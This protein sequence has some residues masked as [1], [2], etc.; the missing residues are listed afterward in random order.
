M[1]FLLGMLAS[2][3][4]AI[5]TALGAVPVVVWLCLACVV[6]GMILVS[7][8]CSCR[9]DRSQERTVGPYTVVSVDSGA[10]LTYTTGRRDKRDRRHEFI[11]LPGI[12]APAK[13][14]AGFDD[15]K[16]ALAL[17][18]PGE[19]DEVKITID[20]SKSK[21]L[22]RWDVVAVYNQ[23]G[24]DLALSQLLAGWAWCREDALKHY[25]TAEK[26]AKKNKLGLWKDKK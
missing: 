3:G 15:S 13:G 12:A 6:I 11:T 16:L 24:Q 19:K 21:R 8:G 7:K 4:T 14:Q 10:S 23:S 17:L 25:Q 18:L 2:I 5:K 1:S 22:D 20:E 9:R 26:L